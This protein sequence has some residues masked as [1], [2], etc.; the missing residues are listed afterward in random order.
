[1]GNVDLSP[2][3]EML[4]DLQEK[5]QQLLNE[6]DRHHVPALPLKFLRQ[7]AHFTTPA[8]NYDMAVKAVEKGSSAA[9]R[10]LEK[11]HISLAE[12]SDTLEVPVS[13]LEAE[14]E[15]EPHSPF[16][17][18][19]SE[20]AQALREDVILR[21][22]ENAIKVFREATWGPTLRFYRPSGLR[23]DFCLDDL[24]TVL[25]EAGKDL[26][27]EQYPVD[28]IVWPKAEQPEEI[29]FV[30]EV[31]EGIEDRLGLEKN[32][33]KLEF[34]V[35]SGWAVAQLPLLVKAAM[36]RLAG[37]IFGIAD[38]SADIGLP[39]IHNDH[40]VCDW[41]RAAIVNMAGTVGVP[42]IDNMT[43]DYPVADNRLSDGENHLFIKRRI[44]HVFDDA[45]HGEQLG[46]DG[47]WVGHP[48]QLF[49]VRLAYRLALPE[50]EIRSETE[51]I[52]SYAQAVADEQG[53]TIIEG[54]MSDRATD[55]HA[56]NKLRKAIA[57]GLL[58]AKKGAE[59]GLISEKE[60]KE[61]G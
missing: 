26:P 25:T 12:L 40:P 45:R 58:D 50:E 4:E 44:K 22:R 29:A 48:L 46:M 37:I 11:F 38:Y 32:Q 33:I 47:K 60:L 20:D 57:L 35:E 41:A 17:M 6:S 49:A 53:A 2:Y 56:R 31:L 42:A 5:R 43:V 8:S 59:L 13:T 34:L 39:A 3:R 61:L 15:V 30:C 27:P 21:G 54:V 14:L 55:R 7:Q 24:V 23:L 28:G 51:K 9:G 36:P 19:D 16:V 18:I 1:M 10:I 52:L